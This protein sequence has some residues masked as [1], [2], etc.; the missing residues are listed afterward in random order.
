MGKNARHVF[1]GTFQ[2]DRF[3]TTLMSCYVTSQ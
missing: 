1:E 3:L 2:I